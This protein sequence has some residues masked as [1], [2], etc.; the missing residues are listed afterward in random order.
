MEKTRLEAPMARWVPSPSKH[1]ALKNATL[2]PAA[3][4][5]F[6]RMSYH[7]I[8]IMQLSPGSDPPEKQDRAIT[9]TTA[10]FPGALV[11]MEPGAGV[12]GF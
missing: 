8:L 3:Q 9:V 7:L 2:F 5:C 10:G 11:L 12:H 1:L 6:S 4:K